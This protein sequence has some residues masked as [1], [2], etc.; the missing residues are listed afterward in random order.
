M[1]PVADRLRTHPLAFQSLRYTAP[2]LSH[3]DVAS[4]YS[5]PVLCNKNDKVQ[6]D[7]LHSSASN[8]NQWLVVFPCIENTTYPKNRYLENYLAFA[9]VC[10]VDNFEC[11]FYTPLPAHPLHDVKHKI[12]MLVVPFCTEH[13][14][15]KTQVQQDYD[16][17]AVRDIHCFLLL[18][19][20]DTKTSIQL[21]VLGLR[22]IRKQPLPH[23]KACIPFGSSVPQDT[24]SQV[25]ENVWGRRLA[26]QTTLTMPVGIPKANYTRSNAALQAA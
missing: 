6:Q 15:C 3:T 5:D 25:S 17:C 1:S 9:V 4:N 7:R 16:Y 8:G 18:N 12:R 2:R 10:A 23:D 14:F 26:K 24:P 20:H 19:K 22:K 11:R 21:N 13:K